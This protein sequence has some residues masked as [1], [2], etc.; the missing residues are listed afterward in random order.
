MMAVATTRVR[1]RERGGKM[2]KGS[3]ISTQNVSVTLCTANVIVY[4][5]ICTYLSIYGLVHKQI[6][7]SHRH[8][9]VDHRRLAKVN[10]VKM[11]SFTNLS[12]E[13]MH[14]VL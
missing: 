10:L 9:G 11:F 5:W 2:M 13:N 7:L 1:E 12:R 8:D 4:T 6:H 14:I 3:L